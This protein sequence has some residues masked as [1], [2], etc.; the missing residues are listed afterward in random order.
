MSDPCREIPGRTGPAVCSPSRI[1]AQSQATWRERPRDRSDWGK[2][3]PGEI[4]PHCESPC[5]RAQ[6]HGRRPKRLRKLRLYVLEGLPGIG[7]SLANRSSASLFATASEPLRS[8]FGAASELLRSAAKEHPTSHEGR[9]QEERRQSGWEN[10]PLF[11]SKTSTATRSRPVCFS[12][13]LS[14]Y[15]LARKPAAAEWM[16][17]P[18]SAL[19]ADFNKPRSVGEQW[20]PGPQDLVDRGEGLV[21]LDPIGFGGLN[22]AAV[23]HLNPVGVA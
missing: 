14:A 17:L 20:N 15:S 10:Y 4:P 3:F 7:S 9:T 2:Q 12:G 8:C 18:S 23:D 11:L 1:P 13:T 6:R 5:D 22:G 19:L 21:K 16:R